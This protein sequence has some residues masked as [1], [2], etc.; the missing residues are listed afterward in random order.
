MLKKAKKINN[1]STNIKA[2]QMMKVGKIIKVLQIMKNVISKRSKP[3]TKKPE[4]K[5]K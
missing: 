3:K 5:D 1:Y 2:I 4:L